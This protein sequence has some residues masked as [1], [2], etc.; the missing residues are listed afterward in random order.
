MKVWLLTW[1]W[2]SD[3]ASVVDRVAGVLDG[4]Y[5]SKIILRFV[6]FLYAR[7]TSN[8]SELYLYA[9]HRKF[10]P[11][12]AKDGIVLNNV[13]HGDRIY[14]GTNPYLYA[15]VVTQFKVE[16]DVSDGLEI[17]SW[18]EP[19]NYRFTKDESHIEIAG[20]GEC[21]TIKRCVDGTICDEPL[22]D[23]LNS[24]LNTKII[25]EIKKCT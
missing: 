25:R 8:V 22:W 20:E 14:C 3:S 4:R 11:Y 18:K 5:S 12:K 19:D 13:P 24:K 17:V 23:R 2:D 16:N 9:K 21:I 7:A 15:R 10:N 6:E 1:E